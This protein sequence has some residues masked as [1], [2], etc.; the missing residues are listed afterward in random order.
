[1][2]RRIVVYLPDKLYEELEKLKRER[3]IL[4]ISSFVRSLIRSY[5]FGEPSSQVVYTRSITLQEQVIIPRRRLETQRVA[6]YGKH[7]L[8][9]VKQLKLAIQKKRKK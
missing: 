1:V 6:V 3:K 4:S 8:E 2:V 5:F 7:Q 9:V